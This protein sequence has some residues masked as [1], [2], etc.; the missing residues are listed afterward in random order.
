[1]PPKRERRS[2]LSTLEAIHDPDTDTRVLPAPE[3]P[4]TPPS[5]AD[6]DALRARWARGEAT[7]LK[8]YV[9]SDAFRRLKAAAALDGVTISEIIEGLVTQWLEAR[10]KPNTQ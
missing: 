9:S 2:L 5:R 7:Q 3:P 8:A 10:D 1:M 6:N 4:T